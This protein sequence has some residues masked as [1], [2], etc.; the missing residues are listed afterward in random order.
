MKTEALIDT[1][2]DTVTPN[3]RRAALVRL[4]LLVAI[5]MLAAF[6]LLGLSIGVRPDLDIAMAGGM[7]WMKVSYTGSLAMVALAALLTLASP[8]ATAPRWFG[9]A[10]LPVVALATVSLV[11]AASMEH[12]AWM[13]L[14]MGHSWRQCPLLI[15]L[16]AQPILLG[17]FAALRSFAPTRLRL[18]GAAAGL[19]AGALSATLYCFHCPEV[20]AAFVLTWYTLGIVLVSV[21]GAIVGPRLLRW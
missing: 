11:E 16:F 9:A 15:V 18:T 8:D 13:A 14:W 19:A 12:D 10:I 17:L 7:F 21:G 4:G 3:P 6:V 2:A 5:G 1:L 20:G